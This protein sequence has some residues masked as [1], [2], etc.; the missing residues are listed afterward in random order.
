MATYA[1]PL[2]GANQGYVGGRPMRT[3]TEDPDAESLSYDQSG[4]A[5]DFAGIGQGNYG[6]M[7]DRGNAYLDRLEGLAS[8][9][10][11]LATEGL[12]QG[13]QQQLA[14]QRSAAAGAAPQNAAMAARVAA[15]NMGRASS[16]MAGNAAMAGIA[17][18]NAATQALG[19]GILGMRGQDVNV[20]L[21]SRGN[22]I[23]ALG[24]VLGKPKEPGFWDYATSIAGAGLNALAL[25]DNGSNTTS[26]ERAKKNIQDADADSRRMLDGL[27]A[28]TYKYKNERDGKG[29]QYGIMAQD[30]ERSGL[31]HAVMDTPEGKK[32]HGAKLATGL[33]ALVSSVHRRVSK[34]EGKGK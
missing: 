26:D 34:L 18:R 25:R 28:Y 12:R 31:G 2:F 14:M 1:N 27:R 32:V 9:R 16:G 20:A 6:A 4:M 22:A 24:N 13:L 11:S 33:A 29:K 7:T 3:P 8:G 17:E 23:Q 10:D 15:N 21:G 30:L 5:S 19:Q